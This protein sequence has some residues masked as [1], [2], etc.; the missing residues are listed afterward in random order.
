MAYQDKNSATMLL[1]QDGLESE[2]KLI[3]D[4]FEV[5]TGMILYEDISLL[6]LRDGKILSGYSSTDESFPGD[7]LKSLFKSPQAD[8]NSR[9][10]LFDEGEFSSYGLVASS[11]S[12]NSV[13]LDEILRKTKNSISTIFEKHIDLMRKYTYLLDCLDSVDEGISACDENGFLTYI[14]KSA[15]SMLDSEKQD[16]LNQDLKTF[17]SNSIL[18]KAVKSKKAVLDV[19]YLIEL[20]NHSVNLMNSA[21]PVFKDNSLIGAIDIYRKKTRSLKVAS[22]LMGHHASYDFNDFIGKSKKLKDTI[23][24][25]KRFSRSDKNVLIIGGSGTG[26]ELMAQAIHNHSSRKEGPFVAINCASYPR[27]LFE[28]ELFGYD[29]G[30]FTGAK[31]GGKIGKFELADGGTIFLDEIGELHMHLQAKLLRIIETKS[32]SRIGSNKKVDIDVRIITAT[33]RNLE[34]MIH[35]ESFREDLYYRLKVLF[36]PLPPL[37]DRGN[38]VLLLCNYFIHKF[39]NDTL[40]GVNGLDEEATNLVLSYDWPGNIRELENIISLSLF[41]CDGE[42]VTKENLLRAGLMTDDSS[43]YYTSPNKNLSAITTELILNT[44]KENDGNKKKTAEQLGI[45]R[46]TIYRKLRPMDE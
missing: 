27:D 2:E 38:D 26:K 15:C 17:V 23:D 46:N 45:S 9:I 21:Y 18:V 10:K 8:Y 34:D 24:I 12:N 13:K 19:E 43:L 4:L 6:L 1:F 16:F 39:S 41:Y 7:K 44:L 3:I 35:K 22:D 25:A 11:S 32:L 36:L 40:K 31:K 20:P 14:N 33:N 37:K 28:S 30:A 5:I 29:E 42:Y